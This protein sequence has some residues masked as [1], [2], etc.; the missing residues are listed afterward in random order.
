[1]EVA[2][3]LLLIGGVAVGPTWRREQGKARRRRAGAHF[4]ETA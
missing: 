1:M 4:A 3:G 2:I